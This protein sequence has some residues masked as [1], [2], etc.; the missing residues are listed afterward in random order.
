MKQDEKRE[1]VVVLEAP[2]E[3]EEPRRLLRVE[4]LEA[5]VAPNALWAD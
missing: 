2:R 4:E 3:Q 5:R 1:E